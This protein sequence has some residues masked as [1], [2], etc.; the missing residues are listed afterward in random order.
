MQLNNFVEKAIDYLAQNNTVLSSVQ[1][2]LLHKYYDLTLDWGNKMNITNNLDPTSYFCENLLDPILGLKTY[3]RSGV[4]FNGLVDLGAG[5]GYVGLTAK[6]LW[7]DLGDCLLVEAVR[8]KVSFMQMVIRELKLPQ[9]YAIQ[10]RA[11]DFVPKTSF[12]TVV[13]RATW[14][15]DNLKQVSERFLTQ[16]KKLLS[17]EGPVSH[18][19]QQNLPKIVLEYDIQPFARKRYLYC[20]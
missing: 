19:A 3:L 20:L 13:S 1:L 7:P 11:E 10:G 2:D 8:K 14:S 16:D 18:Q 17:F 15:W 12:Q 5:G 9:T 4:Q 6:I